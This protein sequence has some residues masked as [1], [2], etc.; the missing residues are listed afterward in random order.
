MTEL[1]QAWPR[2]SHPRAIAIIGSGAIVRTAHL[3]AYRR[4]G[5]PIAGVFDVNCAVAKE[6]S[7]M[8]HVYRVFH[9]LDE[10]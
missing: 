2:P 3:P 8:Y 5:Y 6:T 1:T 4:L 9:S 10:A 7:A